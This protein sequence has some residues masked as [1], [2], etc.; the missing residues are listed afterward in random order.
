M[1]FTQ[2]KI[3]GGSRPTTE[4]GEN[5]STSTDLTLEHRP[6]LP[7]FKHHNKQ[8]GESS[9]IC[10][11]CLANHTKEMRLIPLGFYSL[12]LVKGPTRAVE[13]ALTHRCA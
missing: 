2:V 3:K 5:S 11:K 10:A 1:L 8:N 7:L 6:V 9:L 4:I 13:Q 12:P